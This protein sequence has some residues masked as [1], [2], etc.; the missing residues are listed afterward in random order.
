MPK[1][2]KML[3]PPPGCPPG[4][5]TIRQA[6]KIAKCSE[7][8]IWRLV[9][10]RRVGSARVRRR[11]LL[12]RAD[13]HLWLKPRTYTPEPTAPGR[14]WGEPNARRPMSD[15]ISPRPEAPSLPAAEQA[16]AAQ[17]AASAPLEAEGMREV[18]S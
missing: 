2:R 12:R 13:L 18:G 10:T 16:G 15:R 3:P 5:I 7:S 17:A 9:Y 1:I 11:V 6:M 4:F 8:T 14:G